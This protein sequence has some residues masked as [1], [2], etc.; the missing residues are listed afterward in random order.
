MLIMPMQH[1]LHIDLLCLFMCV[2]GWWWSRCFPS[3]EICANCKC[4]FNP[5][6]LEVRRDNELVRLTK[7]IIQ[8][9]FGTREVGQ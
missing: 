6:L 7:K 9:V 4:K 1:P 3:V 5:H 2:S 8:W